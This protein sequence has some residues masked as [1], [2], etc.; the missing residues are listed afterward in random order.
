M[1]NFWDHRACSVGFSDTAFQRSGSTLETELEQH[2][3]PH[4]FATPRY[5]V[6]ESSIKKRLANWNLF[7]P[8]VSCRRITSPTNERT[9]IA[10]LVPH[11]VVSE[12]GIVMFLAVSNLEKCAFIANLDSPVFDYAARQKTNIALGNFVLK[13]LPV[14]PPERY[15]PDL[16]SFIVP[17]VVELSYT[18]WDLQPFARDVLD[19]MGPETWARWFADAPVHTSPPPEGQPDT[20]APFMWDEERRA[21]LRAELDALYAH[22]Y[23]LTR[24]E[25]DYISDT[26]PIVRRKDEERYGEY[27]TKRMVLE[28]FESLRRLESL[29]H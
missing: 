13:Q 22:L 7:A 12:N 5:W 9:M 3:N 26:F 10:A 27:R 24:E 29:K 2:Q 14:L 23:G 4:Y 16:L 6:V 21:R 15:T 28:A 1:L 8:C 18:A 20:P 17:R 11:P 25:L 19:E